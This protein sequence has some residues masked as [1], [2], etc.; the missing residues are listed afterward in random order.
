MSADKG[1]QVR[2][3]FTTYIIMFL[4]MVYNRI[5]ESNI[6]FIINV[7]TYLLYYILHCNLLWVYSHFTQIDQLHGAIWFLYIFQS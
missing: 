7:K 2:L 5:T 3:E 6:I 4:I 1:V